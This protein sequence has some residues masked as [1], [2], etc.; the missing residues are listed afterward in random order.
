MNRHSHKGNIMSKSLQ[1]HW[2]TKY[3]ET[4][5][6]QLGWYEAKSIPSIQ[7]I[8]N[9]SVSEASTIADIGSGTSSLVRNLLERG[10]QN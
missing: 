2:N 10:Y 6:T 5:T 8:E 4:P 9:C 1:T 7:L 3:A